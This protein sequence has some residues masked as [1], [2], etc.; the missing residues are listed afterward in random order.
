MRVLNVLSSLNLNQG[1]PPEVVRNYSNV[2]NRKNKII[3]VMK[4][5]MISSFYFI[6]T[7]INRKRNKKLKMFLR[8]YD[9]IHFHELWSIKVL[10]L[11][12][13]ARK[14]GKK[15]IVIPHGVLDSWSLREKYLKKKVFSILFL[16]RFILS[17]DAIFS[18]KDEFFEAK[19]NFKLPFAFIIPNG[20]NLE[21]FNKI[22]KIQSKNKKKN[23]FF[24]ENS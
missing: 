13:F 9:I 20:I 1:G 4:L 6:T 11:S 21:K 10:F 23:Y 2:I 22:D 24:W 7:F 8:N 12:H 5:N 16:K 3:A 15:L 19:K 14:L 18:T 17:L